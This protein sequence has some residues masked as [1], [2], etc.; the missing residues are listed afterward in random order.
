MGPA[1]RQATTTGGNSTQ[2][3]L[4]GRIDQAS[5]ACEAGLGVA[6]G[7]SGAVGLC[8]HTGAH[9]HVA[10]ACAGLL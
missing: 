6:R 1:A 3:G 8:L 2:D 4:G 5:R 10:G 9:L 7:K